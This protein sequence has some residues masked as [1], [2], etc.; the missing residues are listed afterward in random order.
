MSP[1]IRKSR[2]PLIAWGAVGLVVLIIVA[3]VVIKIVGG[4]GPTQSSHQAV[5]P[6]S[7]H[8]VKEITTV[9][10]SVFDTVGT[11]IP[12]Q[13]VGTT[14]IV[15]AGQPPLRLLGQSPSVLYYG[16]EYCPFC[17]AERWSIAV[18][19]ARFG[20]W[21][22]LQ[23]TASGL[24]D[25]DYSTITF[26]KARFASPYV[27]FASIEACTNVVSPNV[28]GCSGYTHLQNPTKEEQGVL[29][30]YASSSFVPG[31]S[32]G[33][34]FPYVDVD[35]KVL[36]SGSTYQPGILTGLTQAEIG[37]S[38]SDA[39]NP[40]TQAIVGTANY[41]TASICAGT[42]NMPSNVCTSKGVRAAA[43]ALR[44]IPPSG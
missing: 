43:Q 10:P 26:S 21:S 18:A 20:T 16:A 41:L 42:G 4:R 8:L 9:P 17:A 39:S 22:G 32:Q 7:S 29:A 2:T 36:Y 38:L 14:P 11:G 28:A 1:P 6:A 25:G 44:S 23:T 12:S 30:K 31:N 13:F 15:I 5:L 37:S 24:L 19:L 35:N 34:S 27:H 40:L 3:L 33:I